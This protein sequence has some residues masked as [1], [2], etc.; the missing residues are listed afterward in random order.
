MSE[1]K[2]DNFLAGAAILGL[3]GILVKILGAIFRIPLV[4]II[5]S[6]GLGYYQTAYPIYVM[7]LSIATSGFPVAISKMVSERRVV[8]NYKGADKVFAL[9]FKILLGFGIIASLGIFF[10]AE[11]IVVEKLKNPKAYLA[12]LA[13]SP[14]ILI[15][16]I[17]ASF[18]GY[19]QGHNDMRP[20]AISQIVEQFV[21]AVVGLGLAYIL[22]KK[23]LEYGAA[24]ATFGATAGALAGLS[25]MLYM[26]LKRDKSR[27]GELDFEEES[28]GKLLK[29]LM[30]IA[31]PIIVGALVMPIMN[32]IDLAL[33]MN[34]LTSIGFNNMEANSMYAQLTGMAAALI[35]LPQ[36]IT[37]AI[38][39]SLVPVISSA[40][41]AQ[42]Q[43]KLKENTSLAIRTST[44]IG[45]P[46][47]VGLFVLSKPIIKM[48]FPKEP[49]SVAHILAILSLGVLFLS[50]IQSFTSVLQGLGKAHIPVINLMIG[51][52]VKVILTYTLT[53]IPELNVKGAAISTVSAYIVA[54]VLDYISV[55]KY[56]NV[57]I[58]IKKMIIAPIGT[59]LGMGSI[60]FIS[61]QL[62]F[63]IL[64]K[65]SLAVV[66]S[67]LLAMFSYSVLL[68]K[69]E[70]ITR[71]DLEALGK[72]KKLIPKLE[73]LRLIKKIG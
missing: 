3:A 36:V 69:L 70:C 66:L 7:L 18:R 21:R 25:T 22:A 13:L 61:H 47:A 57:K 12:M 45:L 50:L 64:G 2:K 29:E 35:N 67:M 31:L 30:T 32:M 65:N 14:A 40:Y 20:S 8:G 10:G 52:I 16:P 27:E 11:Y 1:N 46:C 55:K 53:S 37:A 42:N 9:V 72:G 59:A 58:D 41:A 62:F 38:A 49:V 43:K 63:I 73:K 4:W 54:C 71:E 33:V 51:A 44:L 17:M 24:G 15:V 56:V 5:T 48:L 28:I 39:T 26:Y 60:A 23:S 68:F 19:F 6:T 34:I